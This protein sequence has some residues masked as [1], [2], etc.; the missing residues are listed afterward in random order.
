MLA[1]ISIDPRSPLMIPMWYS[2]ICGAIIG[3][4]RELKKKHAGIKTTI[5]I[6]VGASIF[7]FLSLNMSGVHDS[8][9]IISQIVS[10]VGFLGGG[11]IFKDRDNITGL[12]SAAMI[13]FTAAVGT[14][15]GLGM[16]YEAVMS[17]IPVCV[18]DYFF[19]KIKDYLRSRK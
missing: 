19:D 11:V 16:Y 7:S 13:W 1:D 8:S 17:S 2:L 18:L 12:T 5:I 3:L 4:E 15:C 10:G 6:C 14:L 9:R